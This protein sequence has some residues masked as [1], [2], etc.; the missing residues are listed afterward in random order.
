VSLIILWAAFGDPVLVFFRIWYQKRRGDFERKAFGRSRSTVRRTSVVPR[1]R[2][3]RKGSASTTSDDDSSEEEHEGDEGDEGDDEV[4][5]SSLQVKKEF[6]RD[7]ERKELEAGIAKSRQK[8]HTQ[9]RLEERRALKLEQDKELEKRNR[10][11][12]AVGGET[13]SDKKLS[14]LEKRRKFKGAFCLR[15]LLL[16]AVSSTQM[17][18]IFFLQV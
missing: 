1:K 4:R 3:P 6:E 16:F 10:G 14:K 18:L 13:K 8:E 17:F 15:S 9:K 11:D 5:R 2:K 7:A 12:S